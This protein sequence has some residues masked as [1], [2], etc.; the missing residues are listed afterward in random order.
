MATAS[1]PRRDSVTNA[2]RY[3]HDA[4]EIT[5]HVAEIADSEH[6]VLTTGPTAKN[7]QSMR[8]LKSEGVVERQRLEEAVMWVSIGC[9]RAQAT[10]MEVAKRVEWDEGGGRWVWVAEWRGLVDA[11]FEIK[12]VRREEV[13]RR[14]GG[15]RR[16]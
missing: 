4:P 15:G 8:V 2:L 5:F 10:S 3:A 12:R 11:Y 1:L 16:A 9:S 7:G 14:R 13:R 6:V